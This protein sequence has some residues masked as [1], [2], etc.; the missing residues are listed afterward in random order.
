MHY[1]TCRYL[2]LS[3]FIFKIIWDLNS[4]NKI[5]VFFLLLLHHFYYIY[6]ILFYIFYLVQIEPKPMKAHTTSGFTQLGL[7][8]SSD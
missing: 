2:F 4:F 6:S 7:L 5:Y 8:T 3:E 1:P